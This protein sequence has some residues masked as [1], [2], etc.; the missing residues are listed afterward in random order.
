MTTQSHA[1]R[2]PSMADRYR[3]LHHASLIVFVFC[4]AVSV[5]PVRPAHAQPSPCT[6]ALNAALAEWHSIG[7]SEPSKPGQS[8]VRGTDG[9]H[10]T[11][12]QYYYLRGQLS[13]AV[14][15]CQ[16]GRDADAMQKL[17]VVRNTLD[18][19]GPKA[20]EFATE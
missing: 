15:A 20:S 5:T 4:L 18:R 17:Q 2:R 1:D 9:H 8:V 14:Q 7:F 10:L 12:G 6:N 3:F 11:A 16:A 13:G 19:S